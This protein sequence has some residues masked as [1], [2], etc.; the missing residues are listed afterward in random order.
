M[1]ESLKQSSNLIL[2][3][4]ILFILLGIIAI[5]L[6]SFFTFGVN[7]FIGVVFLVAGLIQLFYSFKSW[8]QNGFFMSTMKSILAIV[9]GSLLL[10]FPVT[11]VMTLT[12]LLGIF[13]LLEGLMK[14][15]M[16]FQFRHIRNWAWLLFSGL[17]SLLLSF[18]I[19]IA[20]PMSALWF[21]G[22]LVGVNLVFLGIA[23]VVLSNDI[24]HHRI[25]ESF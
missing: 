4:G 22:L 20:W 18:I 14:I 9:I 2:T 15:M 21:I 6:P 16:A 13:F 7:V 11:A 5:I 23:L 19:L 17:L 8:R 10:F 1:I 3:E 25:I 24:K 12:V